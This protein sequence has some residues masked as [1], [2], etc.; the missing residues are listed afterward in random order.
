MI[1]QLPGKERLTINFSSE[2]T[3]VLFRAYL[4]LKKRNGFQITRIMY[5]VEISQL[6]AKFFIFYYSDIFPL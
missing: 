1:K 5:L 3:F 6:I 2:F 4:K